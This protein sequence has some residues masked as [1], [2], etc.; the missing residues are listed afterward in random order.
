MKDICINGF[1]IA[2][3]ADKK[4]SKKE[5]TLNSVG[6]EANSLNCTF[7]SDIIS[8]LS[9]YQYVLLYYLYLESYIKAD[10]GN[11]IRVSAVTHPR[12][13]MCCFSLNFLT[14]KRIL[15]LCC[16]R[17]ADD[18]RTLFRRR[19]ATLKV[20]GIG[21]DFHCDC[22]FNV[23]WKPWKIIRMCYFSLDPLLL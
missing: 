14:W 22:S 13:E 11:K 18:A 2:S 6:F 5:S 23:E 7:L 3:I 21:H 1:T 10:I 19:R 16:S 17:A 9:I 12:D 15:D 20:S 4:F 8:P